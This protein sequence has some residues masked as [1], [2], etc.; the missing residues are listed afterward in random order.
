[1]CSDGLTKH[2]TDAEIAEHLSKMRST[3]QVCGDLLQLALDR[4]GYDNITIVAGRAP[5]LREA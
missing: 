5:A 3:E 4:G 1:V 2:V